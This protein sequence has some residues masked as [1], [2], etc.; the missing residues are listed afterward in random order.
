MGTYSTYRPPG[1]MRVLVLIAALCLCAG[2]TARLNIVQVADSN[3]DGEIAAQERLDAAAGLGL[4][5]EKAQPRFLE[6]ADENGDGVVSI[7][8]QQQAASA[9]GLTG[10]DS[11]DPNQINGCASGFECVYFVRG[12]K[13]PTFGYQCKPQGEVTMDALTQAKHNVVAAGFNKAG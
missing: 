10:E 3:S 5:G 9:L 11:C 4:T 8:E 13:P 1:L 12:W 7:R 2:G 6:A